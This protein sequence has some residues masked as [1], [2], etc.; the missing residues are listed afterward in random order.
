MTEKKCCDSLVLFEKPIF[1]TE[2]Y[3]FGILFVKQD[4]EKTLINFTL[5]Q[6]IQSYVQY[7]LGCSKWLADGKMVSEDANYFIEDDKYYP[8]E[9]ACVQDYCKKVYDSN[10]LGYTI[11]LDCNPDYNEEDLDAYLL[12]S[13]DRY[14]QLK[15][16]YGTE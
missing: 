8:V 9:G 5:E 7:L 4:V 10:P 3:G 11:F 16:K 13:E 14:N 2:G 15:S 1:L 6:K 12:V